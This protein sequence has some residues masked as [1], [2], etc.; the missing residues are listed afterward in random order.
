MSATDEFP[1]TLEQARTDIE[2]TRA[3]LA[4]TAEAL[5]HKLNVPERAK[6]QFQER[7]AVARTQLKQ[8][9]VTMVHA[10]ER[11]PMMVASAG[12]SVT[13]AV[14]SLLTWRVKR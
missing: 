13:L 3:E 9:A 1:R 7:S 11:N 8:R 2:L 10:L 4:Q 14:G 5:A 6:E 12:A